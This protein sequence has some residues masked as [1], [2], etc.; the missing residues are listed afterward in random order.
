MKPNSYQCWIVGNRTVKDTQIPMYTIIIE[1]FKKYNIKHVLVFERNIPNK[2]MPI[3]NWP[4][5]VAGKI[6]ETMNGE[7]IMIYRKEK[8]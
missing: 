8:L 2:K 6:S 7:I 5:N 3:R 4:T 1:L